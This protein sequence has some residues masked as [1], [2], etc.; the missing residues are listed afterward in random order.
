MVLAQNG[1]SCG[2][3]KRDL[4]AGNALQTIAYCGAWRY[5]IHNRM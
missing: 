1:Q 2:V 4:A 3:V 5:L